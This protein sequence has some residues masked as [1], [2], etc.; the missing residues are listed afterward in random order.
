MSLHTPSSVFTTWRSTPFSF[1]SWKIPRGMTDH[2]RSHITCPSPCE[3]S[4][5]RRTKSENQI[6]TEELVLFIHR[7]LLIRWEWWISE[8][9]QGTLTFLGYSLTFT[10]FLFHV[11]GGFYHFAVKSTAFPIFQTWTSRSNLFPSTRAGSPATSLLL[12]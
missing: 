8:L 9:I 3:N 4:W 10:V 7:D 1:A 11:L 6:A 12:N 5:A 2:L